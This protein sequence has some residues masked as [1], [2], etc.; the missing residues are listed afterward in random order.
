M[1]T[2][3]Q[4]VISLHVVDLYGKC[5]LNIPYMD[6]VG[7]KVSGF[8]QRLKTLASLAQDLRD[9][10]PKSSQGKKHGCVID[11]ESFLKVPTLMIL[12][13]EEIWLTS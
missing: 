11:S 2:V 9:E 3:L 12:L 7:L 4:L 5:R 13:V 10:Q 1:C 6:P 8:L